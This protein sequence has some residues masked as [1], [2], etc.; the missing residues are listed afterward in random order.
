MDRAGS[1]LFNTAIRGEWIAGACVL[2]LSPITN[3]QVK[4]AR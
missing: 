2:P 3:N 4:L 1:F